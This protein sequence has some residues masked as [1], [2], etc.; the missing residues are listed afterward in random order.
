M[1]MIHA[2]RDSSPWASRILAPHL[3]YE[4]LAGSKEKAGP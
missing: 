4:H 2:E 3:A 1:N